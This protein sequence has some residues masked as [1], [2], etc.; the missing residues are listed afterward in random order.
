MPHAPY[1]D[2]PDEDLLTKCRRL[3]AE[4]A[5]RLRSELR[6]TGEGG[7]RSVV[8]VANDNMPER[9]PMWWERD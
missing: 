5:A 9:E 7:A 3:T 1:I 8:P 6:A 2:R 4:N